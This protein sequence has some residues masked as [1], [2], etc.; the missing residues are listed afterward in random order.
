MAKQS[1]AKLF[2][3]GRSQ[4]VRLPQEFRF[5]SDA[6]RIR[7]VGDGVLLE[8]LIPDVARWFAELDRLDSGPVMPGGRRQPKTPRR[9]I[10]R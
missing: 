1:V 10:F 9:K 3:N 4:A 2:R 6:V 7:R 5:D 8:P